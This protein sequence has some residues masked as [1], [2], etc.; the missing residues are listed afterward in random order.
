MKRTQNL[1]II[2]LALV[3]ASPHRPLQAFDWF[4]DI[5]DGEY[6]DSE[7]GMWTNVVCDSQDRPRCSYYEGDDNCLKYAAWN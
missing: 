2:V 1:T 7:V 5:V 4:V 3:L 6:P